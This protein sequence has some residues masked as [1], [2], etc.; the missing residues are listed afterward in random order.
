M[1][2]DRDDLAEATRHRRAERFPQL[3]FLKLAVAGEHEDAALAAGQTIGN[4]HALGLGNAHP[5]RPC[6]RLDVRRFDMR[7][8]GQSVQAAEL[9]ELVCRQQAQ[10]DQHVVERRCVVALGREED[11]TRRRAL[12]EIAQL[13]QEEPAHDLERAEAGADMTRPRAGDH[14]ERVDPRQRG[15][16]TRA[17]GRRRVR[18][19]QPTELA[20]RYV[21]EFE[22][23]ALVC[24][25]VT[26]SGTNPQLPTPNS[27]LRLP[28]T[29]FRYQPPA[30]TTTNL[31]ELGLGS[32]QL[33]IA[34]RRKA[35]AAR[36][37]AARYPRPSAARRSSSRAGR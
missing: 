16:R 20:Y 25:Q 3:P 28:T 32:W 11:V 21:V 4:R 23:F 6:V 12:V 31:W 7:V 9:V 26:H 13:V 10:T 8:S 33:S 36:G 2:D 18:I 27:Q 34:R 22:R 19:E 5:E 24:L 35:P 1:V 30:T 14:V 15:K 37:A 29:S 17:G